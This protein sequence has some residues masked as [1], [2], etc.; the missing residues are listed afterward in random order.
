MCVTRFTY[1][2]MRDTFRDFQKYLSGVGVILQKRRAR[3]RKMLAPLPPGRDMAWENMRSS[4]SLV[5]LLSPHVLP[6]P[7]ANFQLR[8][9]TEKHF[10]KGT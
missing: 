7:L 10:F 8:L 3:G 6:P 1:K 4:F 5:P 9:R 2:H